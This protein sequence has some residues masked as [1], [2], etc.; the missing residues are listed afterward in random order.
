MSRQINPKI[1]ILKRECMGWYPEIAKECG[2]TVSTVS[3]VLNQEWY[4]ADVI[5]AAIKVRDRKRAE[6][7]Q[8]TSKI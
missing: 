5:T 7:E 8:V 6:V 4:N 1:K 3:Q 2:K